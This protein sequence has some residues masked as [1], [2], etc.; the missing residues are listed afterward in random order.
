MHVETM[1]LM[2]RFVKRLPSLNVTPTGNDGKYSV[3]DVGSY[4]VNGCYRP[5]FDPAT[6]NYV[7]LD[8]E[9][10]PNVDLVL[11]TDDSFDPYTI[12]AWKKV[13]D[14]RK[15]DIVISGQCLEHVE[16][17]WLTMKCIANTMKEGG[18]AF[19]IAPS[20]GGEH[21][22][23]IDCYRYFPDGFRALAKHSYLEVIDCGLNF[24]VM[25]NDC[26]MLLRKPEQNAGKD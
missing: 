19:I 23:P 15:F 5:L 2:R 13:L 4:D 20:N 1:E 18:V 21:R 17:P 22:Y 26:Y 12:E 16:Y 9:K 14:D 11:P 24:G 8:V 25:W 7:G 3:L 6:F 10:G